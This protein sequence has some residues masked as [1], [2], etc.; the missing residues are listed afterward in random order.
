ML[1][2]QLNQLRLAVKSGQA[3]AKLPN[4]FFGWDK[5]W[6]NS[7]SW[8]TDG[9]P[10]EFHKKTRIPELHI[11]SVKR[12]KIA[13][14]AKKMQPKLIKLCAKSENTEILRPKKVKRIP[15]TCTDGIPDGNGSTEFRNSGIPCT[16][17]SMVCLV[18]IF[19]QLLLD[20][21]CFCLLN[22][23]VCVLFLY[24]MGGVLFDKNK[25]CMCL[26]LLR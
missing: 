26:L 1:T 22:V 6:R 5:V 4:H 14:F 20:H 3:L 13:F 8:Y 23:H 21:L 17:Y 15:L 2:K 25:K 18:R 12:Q 9:I 24:A 19:D 7:V 10:S 11:C 16:L